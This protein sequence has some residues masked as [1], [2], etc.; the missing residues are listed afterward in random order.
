[1]KY[2]AYLLT[3]LLSN[4]LLA[5]DGSFRASGN[6]L[7]PIHETDITVKKEILTIKKVDNDKI[8]VTVY[9]EFYNPKAAK[10]ITVGFEAF[11]PSGDVD[12]APLNGHHPYMQDFTVLLNKSR[13][14][15]KVAYVSDSLYAKNGKVESLNLKTFEGSTEGNVID[16]YYVYHFEAEFKK[17]INTIQHTYTYDLSGGVDMNFF[18]EYVLTA[19]NRWGNKQIDDFTLI[20]DMGEFETFTIDKNFFNR[21]DEWTIDGIGK[22]EDVIGDE[23]SLAPNDG[24]KFHIQKGT[25]TFKKM[26]F[27]PAGELFIYAFNYYPYMS[28][29]ET[30]YLPFSYYQPIAYLEYEV[31]D[32]LVLTTLQKKILRNLPFA[33]RGYVFKGADLNDYFN[34]LDWY[35]PDPNYVPDVSGL[36]TEEKEWLEK[37]K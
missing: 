29:E 18:F 17:G 26:N 22:H 11:A 30:G 31:E 35:M 28:K 16:F 23:G 27:K 13:L 25:V 12:G 36:S 24:V 20:L 15:Y 37:W 8:E 5:N 9:Y 19:A 32:G 2:L 33:R 10:K 21:M 1:M 3:I 14:P 6:H 34:S 7:I 4:L